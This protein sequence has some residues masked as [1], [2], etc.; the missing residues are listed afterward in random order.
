MPY[1]TT[2]ISGDFWSVAM[3][4]DFESHKTMAFLDGFSDPEIAEIA[5][6]INTES[7][8]QRSHPLWLIA[9]ILEIAMTYSAAYRLELDQRVRELEDQ[10]G[11]ARGHTDL[12]PWE[13]AQSTFRDLIRD[14]NSCYT[15]LVYLERRVHFEMSAAD[16]MLTMCADEFGKFTPHPAVN[17]DIGN[18]SLNSYASSLNQLNHVQ[19]LQKRSLNHL[20]AV[21]AIISQKDSEANIRLGQTNM[22]IAT[23]S[24]SIAAAAKRDSTSMISLAILTATFL[25]G[26][27]VATIFAIGVNLQ[28]D[29]IVVFPLFWLF[30]AFALPLT[31]IV[32]GVWIVWYFGYRRISMNREDDAA[33]NTGQISRYPPYTSD[34]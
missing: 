5:R 21:N 19:S 26:T 30:W 27:F 1:K 12:N 8:S 3:S 31:A 18:V 23:A 14:V 9:N 34:T 11:I 25:P 7:E 17:D 29:H 2:E 22:S 33:A 24:R 32:M 10:L 28:Q 13:I 6:R 20:N 16:Q 4:F 15:A